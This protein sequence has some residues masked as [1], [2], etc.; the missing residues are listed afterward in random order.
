MLRP[1]LLIVVGFVVV[2]AVRNVVAGD[3]VLF[4]DNFD[5]GLSPKWSVVGLKKDD[6][7]IKNGALEMRVQPTK[8]GKTTPVLSLQLPFATSETVVASVDLTALDPFTERG[9]TAGLYLLD[10][11]RPEFEAEKTNVSGYFVFSPP[12][13]VFIGKKGTEEE[14]RRRDFA[15]K[16]WPANDELGA[17]RII[18]RGHQGYFQV[19]PSREGQYLTLFERALNRDSNKRGFALSAYGG[20]S[21]KE[22]WVR[23][24]NFRVVRSK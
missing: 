15:V 12:E 1:N 20:P 16:F 4:E 5:K 3:E 18:V 14:A 17:I 19:G 24:D 10:E 9:E 7:R 23:F 2:V 6:Y 13:L 21:D 8:A 11:D 22:H